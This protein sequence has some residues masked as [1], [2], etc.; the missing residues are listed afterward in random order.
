MA[1]MTD[2]LVCYYHRLVRLMHV[3]DDGPHFPDRLAAL[4][5]TA[6]IKYNWQSQGYP[7]R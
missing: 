4:S 7:A 3:R 6:A 2:V 1:Y 5:D